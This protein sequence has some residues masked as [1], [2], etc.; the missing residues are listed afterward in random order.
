[1]E[2]KQFIIKEDLA[3]GILQYLANQPYKEVFPFIKGLQELRTLEHK[4]IK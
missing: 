2:N 4:D 3:N 1:M